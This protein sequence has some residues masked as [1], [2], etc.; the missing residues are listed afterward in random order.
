MIRLV[1]VC[2]L[3]GCAGVG[4]EITN[5]K[6][7]ITEKVIGAN[8]REITVENPY[9]F[10]L[11]AKVDCEGERDMRHYNMEPGSKVVF[12]VNSDYITTCSTER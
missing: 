2:I 12:I 9:S 7:N 8:K 6:P 1:F 10:K 4:T 3:A 11:S 5:P